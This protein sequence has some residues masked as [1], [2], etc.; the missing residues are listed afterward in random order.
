MLHKDHQLA[1]S[2]QEKVTVVIIKK[3]NV[4]DEETK[5]K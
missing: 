4:P 2:I 3:Q 1:C 5:Q